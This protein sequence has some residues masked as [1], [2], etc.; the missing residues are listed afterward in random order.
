MKYNWSIIGHEKQ[1]ERIEEDIRSDNL[2]HAYLL[3][4]PNSV[5]KSTVAKKLAGI[6]QCENDFCHKCKNCIQTEKGCH[7]DIC[8]LV[9]DKESIKI[10][11][12]RKIIEH[13]AM[14][15]QSKYKILLIQRL[16]RMTIEA[17]NSFLKTLEEPPENTVFIMTTNNVSL[18]LPTI[19]SRVRTI[20]FNNVSYSYLSKKLVELYPNCDEETLNRVNLFSTGKTGR[21]VQLMENPEVLAEYMHLYNV[22]QVFLKNKNVVDR[23]SFVKNLTEE[24]AQIE[25]FLNILLHVLRSKVLEGSDKT[26]SEI[27]MLLKIREAGML[28]KKNVNTRLVLEN[29][30][31]S[32]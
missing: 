27:N 21:A 24:P 9:D 30:M 6:L 3:V 16:E 20:R 26:A 18:I 5:G 32:L 10:G 29:L 13:L 4:G 14:T 22:V 28:L 8:E 1:L 25:V 12:M 11:T 15:R 31:L 17:A 2:A 19:I 7:I 23:F